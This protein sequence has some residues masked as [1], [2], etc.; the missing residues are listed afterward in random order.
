MPSAKATGRGGGCSCGGDDLIELESIVEAPSSLDF[1]GVPVGERRLS[2]IIL[3]STGTGTVRIEEASIEGSSA[4]SLAEQAFPLEIP[5]GREQGLEL[6]FSPSDGGEHEAVLELHSHDFEVGLSVELTGR[7]L[8][9]RMVLCAGEVCEGETEDLVLD[10]GSAVLGE[11]VHAS[12][13]VENRGEALLR[14]SA[15]DLSEGALG[16]GFRLM[17]DVEGAAVVPGGRMDL[18]IGLLG[19]EQG[20]ASASV[21]LQ[22]NDPQRP[23]ASAD[24]AG[25]GLVAAAPRA[26]AGIL[27]LL[28]PDGSRTPGSEIDGASARPGDTVLLTAHPLPDCSAADGGRPMTY[29]WTLVESPPTS[30]ASITGSSSGPA[31]GSAE[32]PPSLAIDAAGLYRV[33]LEVHDGIRSSQPA[34]LLIDARPMDDLTIE[35]TWTVAADMDLHLVAPGGAPFC[36]P[37]DCFWDTCIGASGE[38][39]PLLDWGPDESGNGSLEPDGV[40]STDPVLV[41]DNEGD[42]IV[43]EES[44]VRLETTRMQLAPAVPGGRYL[45]CIHYFADRG[46]TSDSFDVTIRLYRHGEEILE[47]SKTFQTGE[48]GRWLEA[49]VIDAETFEA[50]TGEAFEQAP[51]YVQPLPCD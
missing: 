2:A 22:A 49:I 24:M 36:S 38:G 39:I 15:V 16:D 41:F 6:I 32:L 46:V 26:C 20:A 50:A 19:M 3:A 8:L 37:L 18:P 23:E 17:A 7:G 45:A 34:E 1:G 48:V 21:S 44:G 10:L 33:S 5:P 13:G 30:G 12:L 29:R 4:F 9:P 11:I 31:P 42:R 47:T 25:E 43:D 28:H 27:A 14:I 35:A 40:I 51:A